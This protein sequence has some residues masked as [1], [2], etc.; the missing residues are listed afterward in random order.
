MSPATGSATWPRVVQGGMGAGVSGW[1][2]ARAV[3]REGQLGVVAGTAL[4][5]ILARRLALGD[6]GG[7]MRRALRSFPVRGLSQRI[8]D[9]FYVEGGKPE[10]APFRALPR[11]DAD[12]SREREAL[13]V[14]ANFVEVFLA[15]EGHG[16]PVGVNYLEKI[17][18]PTLPSLFGAMLAGVGTVFM[19]AGIPRAIPGVLDDLAALRSTSLPLQ[20]EGGGEHRVSFDPRA[21]LGDVRVQPRR[22]RFVAI[23][24]SPSVAAVLARK[25]SGT[26]DG[27]VLET[28]AAGGHNAPPRGALKLDARGDPIY[29][30]RDEA[31]TAGM[32]RLGQPFWIAGGRAGS[33]RLREALE[34][35]AAGI[36][37]G[38]AFAFCR[39][40]GLDSDLRRRA[41]ERILAGEASV[42]TDPRASPTGFP[43]KVFE[44]PG[45][46]SEASV[47]RAR[48]RRCDLGY[49]RH[50]FVRAAA[51]GRAASL[52]WRCPGEPEAVYLRSGGRPEDLAGRKCVCNGLLANIGLGQVGSDGQA[53][54]PLLTAGTE[55][56]VVERLGRS[57]GLDYTARDVLDFVTEPGPPAAEA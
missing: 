5:V 56:A 23:V 8:L 14:A 36:Q 13:I 21:F 47:H 3:A 11:L 4:D 10:G 43:F 45:T 54:V 53:E 38:S 16:G 19:G 20:V 44:M 26:V 22:P 55:L 57:L 49:L 9:R 6:P 42:R 2:L 24:S 32:A 30:V 29:G 40:S 12:T 15:R 27:F 41:L 7:D 37:V 18:L 1:R 28:H 52:G 39:E 46:L 17:Q 34:L 48:R 25:A 33:D 35:G 31:D 51:P 50:A